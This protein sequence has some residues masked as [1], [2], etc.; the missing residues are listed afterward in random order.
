[1]YSFLSKSDSILFI[2]RR[3]K[4]EYIY[5]S[6]LI[7][8]GTNPQAKQYVVNR[9]IKTR[10]MLWPEIKYSM[11]SFQSKSDSIIFIPRRV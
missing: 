9:D 5:S 4:L 7:S 1:M 11:Y 10:Y 3:V 2:A 8:I 6:Q